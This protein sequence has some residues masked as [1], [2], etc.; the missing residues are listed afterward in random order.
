MF[1]NLVFVLRTQLAFVA[2]NVG[3]FLGP[4]ILGASVHIFGLE[5]AAYGYGKPKVCHLHPRQKSL[6]AFMRILACMCLLSAHT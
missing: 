4:A 5:A 6:R 3:A 2:H 1:L